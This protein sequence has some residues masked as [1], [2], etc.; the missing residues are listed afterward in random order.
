MEPEENDGMSMLT[1]WWHHEKAQRH[2][3]FT[4]DFGVLGKEAD[5]RKYVHRS[6]LADAL[7]NRRIDIACK[8][9]N[10]RH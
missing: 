2:K 10:G 5:R 8:K 6:E 7:R 4:N 1:G 3:P 9:Q